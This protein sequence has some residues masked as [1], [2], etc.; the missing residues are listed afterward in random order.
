MVLNVVSLITIVSIYVQYLPLFV[1]IH[2]SVI[3]SFG[4][5][6]TP[7]IILSDPVVK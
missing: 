5:L 1:I 6:Y 4:I 3:V 7:L 2:G